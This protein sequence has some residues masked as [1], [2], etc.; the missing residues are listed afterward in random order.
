MDEFVDGEY[1][2]LG[3]KN[4]F[5]VTDSH[6][7]SFSVYDNSGRMQISLIVSKEKMNTETPLWKYLAV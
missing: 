3:L 1:D 2:F 7:R 4:W 5:S 6:N